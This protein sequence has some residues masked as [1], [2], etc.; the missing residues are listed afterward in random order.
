MGHSMLRRS[1]VAMLLAAS[2]NVA[3][4]V[5]D[6]TVRGRAEID[7]SF[8]FDSFL[9]DQ[10]T[11]TPGFARPAIEVSDASPGVWSYL[12]RVDS[13]VPKL[14]VAGSLFNDTG[15]PLGDIEIG[16]LNAFA[17]YTDT[18]TVSPGFSDPYLI[19]INMVV[20]GVLQIAGSNS[21]AAASLTIS[22]VGKLQSNDFSNYTTSGDVHDVLS[23]QYQFIGDAVFDLV[24][25]LQFTIQ[26][27]DPGVTAS[28]DFSH[29]AIINLVV[30]NLNGDPL[31]SQDFSVSSD[32][33]FFA[34]APVPVPAAL[35]MFLAGLAALGVYRRRVHATAV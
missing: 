14:Q 27:I 29:T 26:R 23:A 10:E 15:A 24:S 28:G 31:Q 17:S 16:A 8:P 4:A 18:I 25:T 5:P 30:T 35:P 33:G 11:G 20:D 34:T 6:M 12:A 1:A 9:S 7:G 13:T 2:A 21:R 19:T 32:S 3:M 22:P